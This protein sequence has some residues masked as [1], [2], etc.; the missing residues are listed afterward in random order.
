MMTPDYFYRNLG[1]WLWRNGLRLTP[2]F[3]VPCVSVAAIAFSIGWILALGQGHLV[4]MMQPGPQELNEPA[5]WYGTWL[6]DQGR[7]PFTLKEL[8]GAAQ[9]FSPFYNYVILALKPIL[10]IDYPAHRIVNFI[11]I[12]LILWLLG[13]RMRRL[14]TSWAVVV[15]SSALLYWMFSS[16]IMITARPDALGLLLFLVALVIPWERDYRPWPVVIGLV[17][18]ILAFHCKSYFGVAGAGVLVGVACYRSK[19]E[20]LVMAA[21]F[22]LVLFVTIGLFMHFYPFY[23]AEVFVMTSGTLVGNSNNEMLDRHTIMMVERGWPYMLLLSFALGAFIVRYDW[24]TNLRYARTHWRNLRTPLTKQP[25]PVMGVLLLVHLFIVQRYM[26]NNGG[27][28]FTYHIHLLFPLAML[29]LAGWATTWPRSLIAVIF[30]VICGN[31][32]FV[33]PWTPRSEPSYDLLARR[34][35]PYKYV[36][37]LGST[38]DILARQGKTVHNDGFTVFLPYAFG[39]G[40]FGR[41]KATNALER[42]FSEMI[43]TVRDDVANRRV[44]V[45]L[46]HADWSYVA[47]MGVIRANY[48]RH[49]EDRMDLQ[50]RFAWDNIEFW[51]PK[52][53]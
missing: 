35:E 31:Y 15:T 22:F 36:I 1:G 27:A 10:G 38:T 53:K 24:K 16:N 17:I 4:M 18:A 29:M 26:A 37:G 44:D 41:S 32:N 19:G 47:E 46:T 28:T 5:T 30:L 50:M 43:N 8:P 21:G 49:P 12:V 42:N 3:I 11:C 33:V 52:P 14:G 23:W 39:G 40:A 34:L 48:E 51:Y 6:L 25:L 2:K 9:F 20:A 7:N 45:I 13:S